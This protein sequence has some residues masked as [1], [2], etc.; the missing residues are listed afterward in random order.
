MYQQFYCSVF[1]TSSTIYGMY[2][3]KECLRQYGSDQR[4]EVP[5]SK[6]IDATY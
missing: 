6:H 4:G 2:K 5:V 3:T 1:A